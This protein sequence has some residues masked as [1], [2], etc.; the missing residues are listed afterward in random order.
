MGIENNK[1]KIER[2]TLTEEEMHS[3][4]DSLRGDSKL[5]RLFDDVAVDFKAEWRGP[6]P[7]ADTMETSVSEYDGK[8]SSDYERLFF[9]KG[10]HGKNPETPPTIYCQDNTWSRDSNNNSTGLRNDDNPDSFGRTS[11]D[12]VYVAGKVKDINLEGARALYVS[13]DVMGQV[14]ST[15]SR[16]RLFSTSGDRDIWKS[17]QNTEFIGIRGDVGSSKGSNIELNADE[18]LIDGG[19]AASPDSRVQLNGKKIRIEGDVGPSGAAAVDATGFVRIDAKG[20]DS[21]VS[22]GGEVNRVVITAVDGDIHI[23]GDIG[24]EATINAI[25]GNVKVIG[26]EIHPDASVKSL[27]GEVSVVEAIPAVG[28]TQQPRNM[29]PN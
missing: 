16:T 3:R 2:R 12:I 17:S 14:K 20:K 1:T 13:G 29:F 18:I 15:R 10:L 4:I 5:S 9:K 27:G 23:Y 8:I 22:I 26:G 6:G 19:V 11:D 7:F 25:N 24:P 28:P 21:L